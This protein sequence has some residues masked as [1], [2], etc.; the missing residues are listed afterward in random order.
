MICF[1]GAY[2]QVRL[3]KWLTELEQMFYGMSFSFDKCLRGE[4]ELSASLLKNIYNEDA[5]KQKSADL[6]ARYITR[7]VSSHMQLPAL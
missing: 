2:L 1:I 3:N 5:S 6:L 7:Y 4:G